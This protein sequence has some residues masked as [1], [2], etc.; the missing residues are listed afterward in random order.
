MCRN[1]KV[2]FNFDPPAT[3]EE[4]HGASLQFVRKISGFAK[5]SRVN[6]AVFD[7]AVSSI[8][9]DTQKLLEMLSTNSNRRNR[10][11]EAKHAHE[12]TIKRFGA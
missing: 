12:R 10:E 8:V 3:G 4:I 7:L 1:I 6:E 2:L 9:I 5:P 11:T